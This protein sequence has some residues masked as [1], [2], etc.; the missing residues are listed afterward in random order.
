L[1][2]IL[3]QISQK[4]PLLKSIVEDVDLRNAVKI[5]GEPD[6]SPLSPSLP[7]KLGITDEIAMNSARHRYLFLQSDFYE[8]FRSACRNNGASATAVLVVAGLA[9]IR[10]AFAERLSVSHEKMPAHQGYVVTSSC[11]PLLSSFQGL[12][13]VPKEEDPSLDVFGGYGGSIAKPRFKLTPASEFWSRARQVAS[14]IRSGYSGSLARQKLVNYVHR[15]PKLSEM[16]EKRIDLTKISRIYSIEVANIGAWSLP[17]AAL[18]AEPSDSRLRSAWYTGAL[19]NSFHGARALFAIA[20]VSLGKSFTMSMAYHAQFIT[21]RE[22]DIFASSMEHILN[23]ICDSDQI[24][25][26]DLDKN[27]KEN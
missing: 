19:S 8:K 4:K 18:D 7:I 27:M 24:S 26:H 2:T 15:R 10:T 9:A 5:S 20:S 16:L 6:N 11:R 14:D 22:A 21:E 25:I 13:G 23:R 3:S 1:K 17:C 12:H